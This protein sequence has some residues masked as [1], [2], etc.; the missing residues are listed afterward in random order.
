MSTVRNLPLPSRNYD[1]FMAKISLL[2]VLEVRGYD[3]PKT[4]QYLID[5]ET[6]IKTRWESFHENR[7]K[8]NK[9]Y[10]QDGSERKLSVLFVDAADIN[11]RANKIV[12]DNK[13]KK[14]QKP[15]RLLF[16]TETP[17]VLK[18]FPGASDKI[19][20]F[21]YQQ[22]LFNPLKHFRA[23]LCIEKVP[24]KEISDMF[25]GNMAGKTFPILSRND[26]LVWFLNMNP[27]DTYRVR[28][29]RSYTNQK[30]SFVSYRRSPQIFTWKLFII[31]SSS[32]VWSVG[33][34]Q[35]LQSNLPEK[36]SIS[37]TFFDV[38]IIDID[39]K[40]QAIPFLFKVDQ[41]LPTFIFTSE[42][43]L[44]RVFSSTK[45]DWK[46][47]FESVK[48]YNRELVDNKIVIQDKNSI[49]H[50]DR[51][52]DAELQNLLVFARNAAGIGN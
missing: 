46:D 23:P 1:K 32:Y 36:L 37:A 14:S 43:N 13:V 35:F 11:T 41:N 29:V 38:V 31:G 8:Y 15:L 21:S 12:T 27:G 42:D 24:N 22:L 2:Q 45:N 17:V 4:E 3:I 9:K 20:I 48:F 18:V 51:P 50:M 47:A 26:P 16:V 44:N 40:K 10:T 7:G 6:P 34:D 49:I 33:W 28:D 5:D 39:A 25:K 19:E 52:N 30:L